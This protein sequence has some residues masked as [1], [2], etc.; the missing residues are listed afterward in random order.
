MTTADMMTQSEWQAQMKELQAHVKHL[1]K[2]RVEGFKGL[3]LLWDLS[4]LGLRPLPRDWGTSPV[5][6]IRCSARNSSFAWF[7]MP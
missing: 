7:E 4:P 1:E 6:E 3:G 2:V 5:L